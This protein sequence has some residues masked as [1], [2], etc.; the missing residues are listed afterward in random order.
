MYVRLPDDYKFGNMSADDDTAVLSLL[1][2]DAVADT[3]QS[4]SPAANTMLPFDTDDA[5]VASLITSSPVAAAA[6][7]R[8]A[9][10]SSTS[11]RKSPLSTALAA[12]SMH[13]LHSS[14]F[15]RRRTPRRRV[16]VMSSFITA[17]NTD[18]DSGA[19][20]L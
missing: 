6:T 14:R 3:T 15:Q 8:V 17:A 19:F 7:H 12:S 5:D 2:T 16:A 1:A 20:N 11:H 13:V 10:H 18:T 4:D 9:R